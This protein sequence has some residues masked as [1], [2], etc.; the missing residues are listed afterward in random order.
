MDETKTLARFLAQSR[1]S[2]IPATIR[3]EGK[4]AFLNWLGCA[5]GGCRDETVDCA[6]NAI[7]DLS[8][9]RTATVLGRRARLDALN[10]AL[11]NAL[12][13]NILDYDDTHMKTVIHPSVPVAAAVLAL[14]EHRRSR[15]A[16]LLH[17]FILG[18]EA[19]CR[20]GNAV[21]PQHY[22]AGWHITATCGV[23]GAAA[24]AGK[25]LALDPQRMTWALGIAATQA[26]GLTAMMGSMSKSYSMA[27]ASKSGLMAALL[28]ERNFTSSDRALEAPRGFANVLAS[29]A[30]LDE[31]TNGLGE[32]WE[33]AWN[34]YK[35]FPCGIVLHAA[36]DG[37]VQLRHEHALEAHEIE[38]VDVRLH[39]LALELA[40]KPEPKTGLEGKL[41]V[42]HAIAVALLYG[43]AGVAEFTD[44]CVQRREAIS[45]RQLVVATPDLALDKAAARVRIALKDGR[46]FERDVPY[47]IGS[48][49]KPMSDRDLEAKF[50]ELAADAGC[51]AERLI[52]LVWTVDALDDVSEL[53]SAAALRSS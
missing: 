40:G 35:P 47:A 28:A 24:A 1:W 19:E 6:L 9:P 23:F 50:R 44:E 7:D 51:D 18:V 39:P 27:H 5:L 11:A 17:A 53:A 20:V 41:S 12:S 16:E 25:L 13:S 43:R 49:E 42:Y 37:C 33:L 30:K 29:E 8:G 31:I 10:A 4:R 26:S 14:T 22:A 45:L 21:S 32:T 15:G 3:H 36:I 38:R 52:E 48:L 2:D 46:T 34:A